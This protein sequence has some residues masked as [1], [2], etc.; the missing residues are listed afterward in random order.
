MSLDDL[1]QVF[2]EGIHNGVLRADERGNPLF[3]IGQR[4]IW[5][6]LTAIKKAKQVSDRRT[7]VP[8]AVEETERPVDEMDLL[9]SSGT[10]Y[11]EIVHERLDARRVIRVVA[12]APLRSSTRKAMEAMLSGD[13]GDLLEIGANR[14]LATALGV[15]PQRASQLMADLRKNF[16]HA[17]KTTT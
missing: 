11:R 8:S 12:N 17:M 15:S 10:D 13:A 4:G 16:Q 5:A 9:P 7:A 6:A 3:H 14:R 2:F 1:Q